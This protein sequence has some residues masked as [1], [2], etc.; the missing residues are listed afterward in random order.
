MHIDAVGDLGHVAKF[1][2]GI[3]KLIEERRNLGPRSRLE[4]IGPTMVPWHYTDDFA[5]NRLR[6]APR[7]GFARALG[8]VANQL[9][10]LVYS[11]ILWDR[12]RIPPFPP[13]E[14]AQRRLCGLVIDG[15]DR[16]RVPQVTLST[17]EPGV[18]RVAPQA[19]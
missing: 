19:R 4:G 5:V 14:V 9:K 6:A 11:E 3:G 15:Q 12:V 7:Q 16:S 18:R 8:A 10:L 17:D 2:I 1:G 13:F